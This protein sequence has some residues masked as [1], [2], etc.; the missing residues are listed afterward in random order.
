VK[1]G[2]G[3]EGKAEGEGETKRAKNNIKYKKR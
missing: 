2:R 1:G 3:R